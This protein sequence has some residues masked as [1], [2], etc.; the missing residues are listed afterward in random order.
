GAQVAVVTRGRP[1]P[2]VSRVTE[3]CIMSRPPSHRDSVRGF[4]LIELLVVIAIIGVLT[5]LLLPAVQQAREAARRIR[6][7]NNMKQL[8]LG[9]HNYAD[10]WGA[11]PAGWRWEWLTGRWEGYFSTG[12]GIFQGLMPFVER[13]QVFNSINF[14]FN[15]FYSANL[16][17]HAVATSTLWC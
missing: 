10:T 4:T 12:H 11:L 15:I 2:S 5:A 14:H 16:T 7:T 3:R 6:C 17:V 1:F 8:A 13:Q 9:M